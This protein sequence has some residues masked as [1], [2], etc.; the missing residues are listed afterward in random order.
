MHLCTGISASRDAAKAKPPSSQQP[1]TS[2]SRTASPSKPRD[3]NMQFPADALPL[4][5][6]HGA[7]VSDTVGAILD[8]LPPTAICSSDASIIEHGALVLGLQS[9]EGATSFLDIPVGQVGGS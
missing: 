2:S 1:N 8:A 7:V 9:M 6:K 4:Q 5:L 3:P